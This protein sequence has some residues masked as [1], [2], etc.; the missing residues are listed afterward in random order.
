MEGCKLKILVAIGATPGSIC[1]HVAEKKGANDDM[2]SVDKLVGD[3]GWLGYSMTTFKS[4]N[5]PAIVQ[6]LKGALK[7]LKVSTGDQAMGGTL[8]HT[9]PRRTVPQRTREA[10]T[11]LHAHAQDCFGTGHQRVHTV[12]SPGRLLDGGARRIRAHDPSRQDKWLDGVAAPQRSAVCHVLHVLC[13]EM[14]L[15]IA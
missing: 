14:P 6:V 8:R 12:G 10:S 2:Y 13:W 11:R 3:A 7:S 5:G 4:D 9:T 1:R 15:D